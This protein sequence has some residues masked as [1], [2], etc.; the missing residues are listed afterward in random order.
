M[1]DAFVRILDHQRLSRPHQEHVGLKAA[2][3]I[4]E[5]HLLI[6]RIRVVRVGVDR[7]ASLQVKIEE[8]VGEAAVGSHHDALIDEFVLPAILDILCHIDFRGRRRVTL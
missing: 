5:D 2:A 3:D 7:S 1:S 4:V 8:D 6:D